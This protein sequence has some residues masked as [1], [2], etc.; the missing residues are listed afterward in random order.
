[1]VKG[2]KSD[3]LPIQNWLAELYSSLRLIEDYFKHDSINLSIFLQAVKPGLV[4]KDEEVTRWALRIYNKVLF[5][6]QDM[7]MHPVGY[8]WYSNH[9]LNASLMCIK[10]HPDLVQ[11]LSEVLVQASKY[12]LND[13]FT[14][15]L[16]KQLDFGKEYL[17]FINTVLPFMSQSKQMKD[18]L[19]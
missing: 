11:Q 1:M 12:N 14:V 19:V 13:F 8:D 7:D 6:L 18:D 3:F 17:D 10:R 2:A 9:G 5:D 4:S 16:R 15:Q